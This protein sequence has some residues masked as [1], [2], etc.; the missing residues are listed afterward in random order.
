MGGAIAVESSE[1]EG[2]NFYFTLQI[3]PDS[4]A[5]I[6]V[7]DTVQTEERETTMEGATAVEGELDA[8]TNVILL[9]EATPHI[10]PKSSPLRGDLSE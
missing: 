7:E 2:S 10:T 4:K 1:G 5:E 6:D 9:P 8:G 3:N